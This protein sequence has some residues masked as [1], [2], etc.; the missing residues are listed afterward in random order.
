V[1][2]KTTLAIEEFVNDFSNYSGSVIKHSR[3]TLSRIMR[4]AENWGRVQANPI[5]ELELPKG[6]PVKQANVL[7]PEELIKAMMGL[8]QP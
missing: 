4:A 1:R 3:A 2:D 8:E 5:R 7:T 6:K